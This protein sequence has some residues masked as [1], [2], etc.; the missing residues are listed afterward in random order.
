L[1]YFFYLYVLCC[2]VKKRIN[3]HLQPASK[4]LTCFYR[5]LKTKI[6]WALFGSGTLVTKVRIALTIKIDTILWRDSTIALYWIKSEFQLF[7]GHCYDNL[8]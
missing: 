2:Y 7:I 8:I 4:V 6:R 5:Y 3:F 1:F